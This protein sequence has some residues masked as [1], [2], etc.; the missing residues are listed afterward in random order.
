MLCAQWQFVGKDRYEG[1]FR[2]KTKKPI[3]FIGNT[4]DPVT[5]LASAKAMSEK[6]EGSVVLERGGY[7]VSLPIYGF[8]LMKLMGCNCSMFRLLEV[9]NRIV[10]ML[11]FARIFM[12]ERC[13]QQVPFVRRIRRCILPGC[14]RRC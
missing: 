1:D 8:R 3:L 11:L 13:L 2:V 12:R 5:P 6:F 14:F 9:R 7:G 4:Y 10:L